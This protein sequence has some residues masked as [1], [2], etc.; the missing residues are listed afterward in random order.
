[1]PANRLVLGDYNAICAICGLK[2]KGSEMR[3]NWKKQW[4]CEKDFEMRN[5]QD[6]IKGQPDIPALPWTQPDPAATYISVT[7]IATNVGDQE[8]TIPNPT[9]KI[10]S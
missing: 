5:E 4:V 1:M 9:H 6:F 8:N 3:R 10:T 2:Y 7:Y